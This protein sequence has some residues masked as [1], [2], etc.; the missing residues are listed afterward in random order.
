M[1]LC[2]LCTTECDTDICY[3]VIGLCL[4]RSLESGTTTIGRFLLLFRSAQA[5]MEHDAVRVMTHH[6]AGHSLSYLIHLAVM[7]R[8]Q[9]FSSQVSSKI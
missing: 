4:D 7:Y 3:L 1:I 5:P 2:A 9:P 6:I 8:S